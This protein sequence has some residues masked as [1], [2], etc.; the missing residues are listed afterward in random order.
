[1]GQTIKQIEEDNPCRIGERYF[2]GF[3][4]RRDYRKAFP[5]LLEAAR[6][7]HANCQNLV[8]YCY[9]LGL[10]VKASP[11]V[12]AA[13]YAKTAKHNNVEAI[14]NLAL[15]YDKG[16]GVDLNPRKA[17]SLY[18]KAAELGDEWAQCNLAVYYWYHIERMT[19]PIQARNLKRGPIKTS[20]PACSPNPSVKRRHAKTNY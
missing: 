20:S 7:G 5:Y 13:W 17:F 6:K 10:G 19:I 11:E 9:E 14:S 2:F 18:K 4:G 1:M 15:L 3:T 8:G 12:A 16:K